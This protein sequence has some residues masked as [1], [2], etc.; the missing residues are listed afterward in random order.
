M[1]DILI[2]N[3]KI[4]VEYHRNKLLGEDLIIELEEL[5]NT[6]HRWV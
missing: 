3:H 1:E 6:P 2:H 5:L 4:L